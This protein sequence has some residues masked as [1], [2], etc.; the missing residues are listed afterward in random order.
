MWGRISG[1]LGI[2]A[3]VSIVRGR[4]KPF[5]SQ[6]VRFRAGDREPLVRRG[7]VRSGVAT[8]VEG[9]VVSP[10]ADGVELPTESLRSSDSSPAEQ[11]FRSRVTSIVNWCSACLLRI[12]SR[13]SPRLTDQL[14]CVSQ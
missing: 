8:A 5:P 9:A 13:T 10:V 4:A 3:L 6:G 2:E 14:V 1:R 12:Q 7:G 11:S